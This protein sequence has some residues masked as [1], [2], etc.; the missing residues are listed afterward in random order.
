MLNISYNSI[1]RD[2]IIKSQSAFKEVAGNNASRKIVIV[3]SV[4][5]FMGLI[6]LF[7]PWRQN[8]SARG[9]ITTLQPEDREQTIHS[10][11]S[12]R[13]EKWFVRE[14][15]EVAM[16]DTIVF[17][18][19]IKP[20][21]LD[22]NIVERAKEQ[23]R[24]KEDAAVAYQT[25]AQAL[26]SQ[27]QA[28]KESQKLKIRQ[29]ENKILQS[30]QKVISDSIEYETAKINLEIAQNQYERQ[31][32]LYEQGLK[33]LTDL[34]E[35]KQ[36]LQERINKKITAE[37]KLATSRN[38]LDNALLA[39]EN[40]VNEFQ[41]KISKAQSDR[42]S[43][44]SSGFEARGD[45]NKLK[46]Q[47]EG[48]ERRSKW[49]YITAPQDG[50]VTKAMVTG[51]GETVKEGE[52]MFTFIPKDYD[53][54]VEMYVRPIDLPLIREG[55]RVQ[56]QFDGWP[57]LVFSGWPGLSVGTYSGEVVAYDKAAS[58]N[59]KFRVLVAPDPDE[60]PWPQL[61]RLGSGAKG[62]ALL[63]RVPVWYELWRNLNGFPPDFY[64]DEEAAMEEGKKVKK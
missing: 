26:Q 42:Q 9:Q 5:F 61:L 57:A 13:V 32:K 2:P 41:E 20:T 55:T 25:K 16:G 6:I 24:A 14:G 21:Y 58:K 45:I 40:L 51:V 4:L 34:Q 10:L 29:A 28:L 30:K 53:L 60:E 48:Y 11:I 35:R 50:F 1:N 63:K 54:A 46:I 3:L 62:I 52:A 38:E 47:Q 33:S 12:G 23:T 7:F 43:A 19:E 8:I 64:L 22:P 59:G 17:I 44:L 56:F 37:N 18:S 15:Q 31:E 36:K 49:Y 39:R 27:I